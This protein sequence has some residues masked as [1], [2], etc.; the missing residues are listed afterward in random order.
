MKKRIK[1]LQVIDSLHTGGAEKIVY[2]LATCLDRT[3]YD[4]S[5]C[6]MEADRETFLAGKLNDKGIKVHFPGRKEGFD[7]SLIGKISDI[8]RT[9]STDILHCHVGGE[10]Y[11][12]AGALFTAASVLTTIHGV[13]EYSLKQ[14]ALARYCGVFKKNYKVA[15]SEEL[16]ALYKCD[17][18][19]YN[20]TP[21]PPDI[22]ESDRENPPLEIPLDSVSIG[23]VG[24]LSEVKNHFN[25]LDA[26]ASIIN[27]TD[28]VRFFIVGSGPLQPRLEEYASDLRI[29]GHTVFTGY[30]ADISKIMDEIDISVL[31]S[32][33][34]G[35]PIVILESMA[36][37]TPVVSTSV[38]GI[39]ELVVDGETGILVP[40]GNPE[41][42]AEAI[43]NL[44]RDADLRHEM[45]KASR[46]RVERHFSTGIMVEKYCAAYGKLLDLK[47]R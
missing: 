27:K 1:I 32:D 39:P 29:S 41:A 17:E 37:G 8:I 36:A 24:R 13:F 18:L 25:F 2:D 31:S 19:I 4:V 28:N 35:L 22:S 5:V 20:G 47:G 45:G 11:G 15:V 16:M 14:R 9:E 3:T 38:G 12:H 40:P 10:L 44:V 23:I 21:F 34:E 7:L 26:A 46:A 43:L 30:R 6:S 33:S 42:L